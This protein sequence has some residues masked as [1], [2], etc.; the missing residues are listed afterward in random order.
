M[1][2]LSE[3]YI[4][5]GSTPLMISKLTTNV[6]GWLINHIKREDTKL[7]AHIRSKSAV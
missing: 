1:R 3:E 6:G 2:D 5:N 7:A 4:K